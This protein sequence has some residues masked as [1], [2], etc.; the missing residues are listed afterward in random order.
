M[1]ELLKGLPPAYLS[2]I[3][4]CLSFVIKM[5][6]DAFMFFF[7]DY[8]R[9]RKEQLEKRDQALSDNTTAIMKL[10]F[11]IEQLSQLLTIV[12]KIKA[13]VDFAHEKIRTIQNG[14]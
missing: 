2:I 8:W 3:I 7:K 10:Q 9:S 13:D 1:L 14:Q 4:V 11:Q 6:L 12:P 5:L